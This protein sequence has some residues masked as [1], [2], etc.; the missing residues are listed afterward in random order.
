MFNI[1]VNHLDAMDVDTL[2]VEKR[3][4]APE[5]TA[6]NRFYPEMIGHLI[7]HVL[8][9]KQDTDSDEVIVITDTVPL[10][11]QRQAVE[12][13][14]KLVLS[15]MLPPGQRYQILHHNSRSHYGLQIADYCCWAV[16]RKYEM[17][18]TTCLDRIRP[19]LRS[20]SEIFSNSMTH[21]Y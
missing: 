19:A 12:K 5:L 7:R 15:R 21:Y 13:S 2:I 14:I 9:R 8:R 18:E 10:K 4:T 3:K 1:I 11:R 20:E 16:A 6:H 17:G